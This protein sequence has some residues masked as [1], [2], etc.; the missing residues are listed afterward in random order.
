MRT[1]F[2]A[3]VDTA[4]G[5]QDRSW[6]YQVDISP[7][8]PVYGNSAWKLYLPERRPSRIVDKATRGKPGLSQARRSRAMAFEAQLARSPQLGIA[9]AHKSPSFEV[10]AL[11][12]KWQ[13]WVNP[14]PPSG[15]LWMKRKTKEQRNF[16]REVGGIKGLAGCFFQLSLFNAFVPKTCLCLSA[17]HWSGT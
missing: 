8:H 1:L 2:T 3:C 16:S 6:S 12:G 14:H 10:P 5:G 7:V 4:W 13:G 15:I 17:R 9:R 11:V